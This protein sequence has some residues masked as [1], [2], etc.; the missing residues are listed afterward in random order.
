MH[1][2]VCQDVIPTNQRIP[3]AEKINQHELMFLW[4]FFIHTESLD[5]EIE[6]KGHCRQHNPKERNVVNYFL[7]SF[8]IIISATVMA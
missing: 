3:Y 5:E 2:V 7:Y 8:S 1:H 6:Q 4:D